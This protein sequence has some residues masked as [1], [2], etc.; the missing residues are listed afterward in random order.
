M[1]LGF[2][3]VV[4]HSLLSVG[5]TAGHPAGAFRWRMGVRATDA[6]HWL[7]FDDRREADLREK[8]VLRA[9]RGDET[10][11]AAPGSE[12]AAAEVC[13]LVDDELR[14]HGLRGAL[15]RNHPLDTAGLSVQEDLCLL[16][17]GHG[18]WTMTAAS[19]SFPTRWDVRAKLGR[20]LTEIHDP[21]P[22]YREQLGER[23][24]RFF[25]RMTPGAIASRLNW[26]LVGDDRRRLDPD[27]PQAPPGMP[28][29]P[30]RDLF[31]RVERQTLRRL[32]RHEAIV[33]GIRIH[34]WPLDQVV[35]TPT[36]GAF[37]DL[38]ESMP[39]DIARYKE[40]EALRPGLV[41]WLGARASTGSTR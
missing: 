31:L 36:A 15:P 39:L 14:R 29:D 12:A 25:E 22:G 28:D 24:E 10:F 11:V 41:D 37:A 34:G 18:S 13:E 7:Q 27:E 6:A 19:V 21:V 23:V 30:G 20:S 4:R 40:L 16:E 26:S 35:D 1:P 32:T 3:D 5:A 2:G 8:A 17:R 33:F 9:Q 38:L